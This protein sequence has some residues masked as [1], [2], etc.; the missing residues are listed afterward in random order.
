MK[1]T[2]AIIFLLLI[3]LA[4]GFSTTVT[5]SVSFISGIV[6]I[7][8]NATT[9]LDVRGNMTI[10][11]E[12]C[13]SDGCVN[14]LVVPSGTVTPFNLSTCPTGWTQFLPGSGRMLLGVGTSNESFAVAHVFNETGGAENITLTTAEIAAHNH[15]VDVPST[16]TAAASN[17]HSFS[18][19]IAANPLQVFAGSMNLVT[20]ASVS[21]A[22]DANTHTVSGDLALFTTG[23]TGGA[24]NYSTMPSYVSLLFCEKN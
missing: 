13:F 18:N 12:L 21:T 20:S 2:V 7:D 6:G 4:F 9:T 1:F 24:A 19:T 8:Q 11:G 17:S 10:D 14:E 16:T 15:T 23:S 3:G 22:T 5:D